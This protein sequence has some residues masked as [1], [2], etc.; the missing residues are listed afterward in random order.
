MNE[1]IAQLLSEL[2]PEFTQDYLTV[3][4]AQ[5][6]ASSRRRRQS[7]SLPEWLKDPP[8]REKALEI[9]RADR[10]EWN[11]KAYCDPSIIAERIKSCLPEAQWPHVASVVWYELFSFQKT[12]KCGGSTGEAYADMVAQ[13]EASDP[14]LSL[15]SNYSEAN[16]MTDADMAQ[17]LVKIGYTRYRAVIRVCGGNLVIPRRWREAAIQDGKRY[18][19]KIAN[20]QW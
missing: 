6:V 12:F 15:A 11:H 13:W 8:T 2:P 3:E 16:E 14:L 20:G 1:R 10:R 17:A 7:A 19:T 9:I 18:R 4:G 5:F